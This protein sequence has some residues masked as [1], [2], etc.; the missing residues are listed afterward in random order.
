LTEG[1][2]D[3]HDDETKLYYDVQLTLDVA[4][5]FNGQA[6]EL[7]ANAPSQRRMKR[8]ILNDM[9]APLAREGTR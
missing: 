3:D 6:A 8:Y 2:D 1:G 9:F 7:L 5:R 4:Y